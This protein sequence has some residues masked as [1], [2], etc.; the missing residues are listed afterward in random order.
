MH[1]NPNDKVKAK[2]RTTKKNPKQT[3]HQTTR[4]TQRKGANEDELSKIRRR[5][6]RLE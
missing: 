1:P 5:R 4:Q 3:E 6:L 2:T